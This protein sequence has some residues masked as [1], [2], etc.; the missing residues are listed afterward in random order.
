MR[1]QSQLVLV[2][3]VNKKTQNIIDFQTR[4]SVHINLTRATHSEYR[5]TL[6][7]YSLS[8]QEVFELF[9]RLAAE[10][11]KRAISILR[12][13]FENKRTKSVASF[14]DVE[15]RNLYDAISEVVE[16]D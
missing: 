12:E 14:N 3:Q 11:D 7:D 4:K 6:F 13:A 15:K 9:A 10:G 16:E 2:K 5:K 1:Y 8:M